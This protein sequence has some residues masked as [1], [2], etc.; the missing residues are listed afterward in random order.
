MNEIKKWSCYIEEYKNEEGKLCARLRDKVT[1]KKVAIVGINADKYHL[2]RFMSQAKNN[3]H[4]MPTVF[5]K[6]GMNIVAVRGYLDSEDEDEIAV[7]I[8]V[9]TGGY[10]FE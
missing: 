10:L 2:L 8:E 3:L 1:N 7:N 9:E 5:D 4:M 6:N